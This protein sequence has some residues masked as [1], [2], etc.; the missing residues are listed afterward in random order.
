[1]PSSVQ[2][3]QTKVAEA[4]EAANAAHQECEGSSAHRDKTQMSLEYAR[5]LVEGLAPQGRRWEG[6]LA[7][8]QASA[9]VCHALQPGGW[10][11]HDPAAPR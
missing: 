2:E 6:E 5:Q 10:Q 9:A 11:G 8:M 1:M 4:K 7:M 3:A